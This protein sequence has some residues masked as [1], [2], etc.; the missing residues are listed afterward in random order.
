MWGATTKTMLSRCWR[1]WCRCVLLFAFYLF[2][3][4]CVHCFKIC[5]WLCICFVENKNRLTQIH[6][7]FLPIHRG[8]YHLSVDHSTHPIIILCTLLCSH[9][10]SPVTPL[11]TVTKMP[12]SQNM[13]VDNLCF[14]HTKFLPY[15]LCFLF[16]SRKFPN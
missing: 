4:A 11:R 8:A 12:P 6:S 7:L 16:G 13:F 2:L 15:V 5:V 9:L 14:Q 10:S 1:W 3:L